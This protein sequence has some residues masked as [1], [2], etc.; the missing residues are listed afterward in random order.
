MRGEHYDKLTNQSNRLYAVG[1]ANRAGSMATFGRT[2]FN[3]NVALLFVQVF[4]HWNGRRTP[5]TSR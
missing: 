1:R 2:S 5:P 4:T 3:L